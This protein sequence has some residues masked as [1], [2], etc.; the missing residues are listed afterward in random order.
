M[1]TD[2]DEYLV[3]QFLS[4]RRNRTAVVTKE[5]RIEVGFVGKKWSIATILTLHWG[6]SFT[7]LADP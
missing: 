6:K 7:M 3:C 5:G 2:A 4:A 1:R